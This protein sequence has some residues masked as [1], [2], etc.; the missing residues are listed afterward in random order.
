MAEK[1]K[2][3]VVIGNPPYQLSV[4]NTEGNSSKAKAIYHEFISQAE[5]LEPSYLVMVT[6]SR[7]MTRTAEGISDEWVSHMLK[8]KRI[9]A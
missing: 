1:F 5:K 3:D 9:M 4:G 2:F 6:P 7:W 8:G